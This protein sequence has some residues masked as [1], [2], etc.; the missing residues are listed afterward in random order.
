MSRRRCRDAVRCVLI[1]VLFALFQFG[2]QASFA[3]AQW[4]E[5]ET[6]LL[7]RSRWDSGGEMSQGA[8]RARAATPR[9]ATDTVPDPMQLQ[10][11]LLDT[12]AGDW[13]GGKVT[14]TY[15]A[16]PPACGLPRT[17]A[18]S[19]QTRLDG[20]DTRV[21]ASWAVVDIN[22]TGSITTTYQTELFFTAL[23]QAAG[24]RE[25]DLQ[26][27]VSICL[28]NVSA[29]IRSCQ[30][31]GTDQGAVW[32]G[33]VASYCRDQSPDNQRCCSRG[34]MKLFHLRH[35]IDLQ[36]IVPEPVDPSS[37]PSTR[38]L[39][40]ATLFDWKRAAIESRTYEF[41]YCSCDNQGAGLGI[42][43]CPGGSITVSEAM[44][45][46]CEATVAATD[47][48]VM[49]AGKLLQCPGSLNAISFE[50]RELG[51]ITLDLSVTADSNWIAANGC[52]GLL[53]C[54]AGPCGDGQETAEEQAARCGGAA[55]GDQIPQS[56]GLK[57]VY[58]NTGEPF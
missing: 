16:A 54:I 24:A 32:Q 8:F 13:V 31:G 20:G 9:N 47:L 49:G 33:S 39:L 30:G 17:A 57:F 3:Q 29:I 43:T 48:Q 42:G 58:P 37:D 53:R 12:I 56:A 55:N 41:D 45:W 23:Y 7:G 18:L 26:A 4:T 28:R 1:G 5:R 21:M 50:T 10:S 36:L 52:Y 46:H 15:G 2:A 14:D 19:V 11:R 38:P 25:D 40:P 35:K 44:A 6:L 22:K 51:A 34:T 27:N